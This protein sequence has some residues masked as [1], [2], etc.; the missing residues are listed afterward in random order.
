[1]KKVL[2]PVFCL[3]HLIAISW[4]SLPHSF[5]N[6]VLSENSQNMESRIFQALRVLDETWI[7]SLLTA[8]VNLTGSQQYWDFF[9]PRSSRFHQ[10][11]SVCDSIETLSG[12]ETINCPNKPMFSNLP[13]DF[14]GFKGIGSRESRN[15]R[16]TE[17]LIALNDP[18]LLKAFADYYL[19]SQ[20]NKPQPS[21]K[22][23]LIAHQFELFP[24]LKALGKPGYR[25]DK[26]LY[27]LP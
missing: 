20:Q 5:G 26:L 7:Q 1:M 3:F 17:N 27:G 9:A 6:L 25:S 22:I 15:Y 16:L 10:Y 12:P 18:I 21:A 2:I 14:S 8:Y 11:I 13:V 4:W 23:Y 19:Q 24:E